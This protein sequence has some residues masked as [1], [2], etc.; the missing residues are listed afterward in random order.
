MTSVRHRTTVT[1]RQQKPWNIVSGE[2][3][4]LTTVG[5]GYPGISEILPNKWR[6]FG[7]ATTE[8]FVSVLG[9]FCP[10]IGRRLNAEATWRWV[11][12]IGDISAVVS[13]I[14]TLLFYHPPRRIFCDRTKMQILAELD[15]IGIFLY[16][17]GVAVFLLGLGWIGTEYS[18]ASPAVIVSVVLGGIMIIATFIWDFYG[19]ATRPLFA[20]RLLRQFRPYTSLIV[21]NFA[22]GLA[23]IALTTFVP[24]QIIEVF[25]SDP[26]TAGWYNVP[27]GVGASFGGIV[28]GGLISRIKSIHMQLMVANVLQTL[29][30]GLLAYVNPDRVVAALML[31]GFAN[32]PFEWIL[33]ISYTTAGLHVQQRD[34]GLAYGLLGSIRYFGGAIG[35]TIL[36]TVLRNKAKITV[37]SRV[38]AGIGKRGRLT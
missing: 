4:R 22:T 24:Q 3:S 29:C 1:M 26:T 2:R 9:T 34:I 21:I 25:T 10:L 13:T 37:P 20:R 19:N 16:T 5:R 38:S 18:A 15:Y 12:I 6:G 36:N 8:V 27:S 11:F 33:I 17:A 31:Q 7:L 30:T 32:V 23:H 28:I 14:G 35:S